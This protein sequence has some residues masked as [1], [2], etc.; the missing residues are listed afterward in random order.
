MSGG[1]KIP[2]LNC[3]RKE[4]RDL[5][6]HDV[7]FRSKTCLNVTCLPDHLKTNP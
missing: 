7:C 3:A 6:L 4:W 2:N 5:S 1:G